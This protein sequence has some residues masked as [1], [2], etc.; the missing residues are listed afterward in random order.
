MFNLVWMGR[1]YASVQQ[2]R[3]SQYSM[4]WSLIDG[5]L[6]EL[7]PS[8]WP[9]QTSGY[10]TLPLHPKRELTDLANDVVTPSIGN[11]GNYHG[12]V[13]ATGAFFE[14]LARQS[15]VCGNK[16][17]RIV[18]LLG[19]EVFYPLEQ[20]QSSGPRTMLK[21]IRLMLYEPTEELDTAQ[22]PA[23]FEALRYIL[24]RAV[25][26]KCEEVQGE[27]CG[28]YMGN[29][30]SFM[31]LYHYRYIRQA[32]YWWLPKLTIVIAEK[33]TAQTIWPGHSIEKLLNDNLLKESKSRPA[34]LF[35]CPCHWS[36]SKTI[37]QSGITLG[38][39]FFQSV[40]LHAKFY[41]IFPFA[42]KVLISFSDSLD[43][44]YWGL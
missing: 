33:I 8:P 23:A 37:L 11:V 10:I 41:F 28:K 43:L 1:P 44:Y 15:L 4:A 18:L 3:S 27:A 22:F 36:S 35:T 39:R 14:L 17:G 6:R 2:Q 9:R 20:G 26:Y 7:Y 24:N 32:N 31:I 12:S 21:W 40:E 42:L 19:D 13:G 16:G 34:F 29:E 38:P 25:L 5:R 30:P